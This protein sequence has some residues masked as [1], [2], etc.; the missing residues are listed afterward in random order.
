MA[1]AR[2]VTPA[3]EETGAEK[4]GHSV[5]HAIGAIKQKLSEIVSPDEQP[6][7]RKSRPAA[8]LPAVAPKKAAAKKTITPRKAD[9]PAKAAAKKTAAARKKKVSSPKK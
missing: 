8:K 6:V 2:T 3:T 4:L 1:K 7:V 5:G 9:T